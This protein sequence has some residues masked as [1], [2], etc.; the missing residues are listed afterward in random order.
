MTVGRAYLP[1]GTAEGEDPIVV[2]YSDAT[3]D[4]SP[5]VPGH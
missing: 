3:F 1:G 2:V 4:P 5:L